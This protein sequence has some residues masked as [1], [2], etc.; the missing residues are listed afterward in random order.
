MFR[1]I[2]NPFFYPSFTLVLLLLVVEQPYAIPFL[3]GWPFFDVIIVRDLCNFHCSCRLCLYVCVQQVFSKYCR[4]NT[5]YI[6]RVT[7][8]ELKSFKFDIPWISLVINDALSISTD[9]DAFFFPPDNRDRMYL[10]LHFCSI[11]P[12]LNDPRSGLGPIL[13]FSIPFLRNSWTN[14]T[15]RWS[16]RVISY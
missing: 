16:R 5:K 2:F 8:G 7:S 14:L 11:I 12:F 13:N 4:C 1:G 10:I 3:V 9:G 15:S 6:R